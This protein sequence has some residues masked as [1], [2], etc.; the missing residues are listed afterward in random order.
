MIN[1][2]EEQLKQVQEYA[3]LFLTIDEIAILLEIDF[4][5]LK[6]AVCS[7]TNSAYK[8]YNKGKLLTKIELRKNVIKMAKHGSPQAEL[9]VEDY[10]KKQRLKEV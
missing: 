1:L 9:L 3:S 7:K 8:A 4:S 6:K 5:D 2:S 10:Q